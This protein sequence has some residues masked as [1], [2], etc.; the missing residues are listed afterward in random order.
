MRTGKPESNR[1][2]R[3]VSTDYKPKEE[4][5]PSK[6]K[7]DTSADWVTIPRLVVVTVV[8]LVLTLIFNGI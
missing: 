2:P 8:V 7:R 1:K 3:T 4:S 5:N 6:G